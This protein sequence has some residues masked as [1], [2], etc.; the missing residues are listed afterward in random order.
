MYIPLSYN[1]LCKWLKLYHNCPRIFYIPYIFYNFCNILF[2]AY[3]VGESLTEPM[4]T[5]QMLEQMEKNSQFFSPKYVVVSIFFKYSS[6]R[7]A[8]LKTPIISPL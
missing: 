7:N 8:P 1:S 6:A 5:A 4:V 3:F 2:Y